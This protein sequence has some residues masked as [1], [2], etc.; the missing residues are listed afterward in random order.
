MISFNQ[1]NK[2][3]ANMIISQDLLTPKLLGELIAK[4]VNLKNGYVVLL[5]KSSKVFISANDKIA[6]KIVL[7]LTGVV[8]FLNALEENGYIYCVESEQELESVLSFNIYEPLAKQSDNAY[9]NDNLSFT[10][11]DDSSIQCCKDDKNMDVVMLNDKFSKNIIHYFNSYIYYTPALIELKNNDFEPYEVLSYKKA[12]KTSKTNNYVAW[13]C[14]AISLFANIGMT[15]FNNH[16]ATV[17]IDDNQYKTIVSKID[18]TR[19]EKKTEEKKDTIFIPAK[20]NL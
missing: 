19:T 14:L 3:L 16:Y 4:D 18:S 6:N 9:S 10:I 7:V 15:F 20:K 5:P 11:N 17:T 13:A 12:L 8:S 1:N 2:C